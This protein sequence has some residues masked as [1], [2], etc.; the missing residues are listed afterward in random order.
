M[1]TRKRGRPRTDNRSK[2]FIQGSVP[3]AKGLIRLYLEYEKILNLGGTF[4][5]RHMILIKAS[6]QEIFDE[7][8]AVYREEPCMKY[9]FQGMWESEQIPQV[10]RGPK[11]KV[12]GW[13][14]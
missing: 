4:V 14:L 6:V 11:T 2:K 3:I 1:N 10:R 8:I 7:Y 5:I 12:L 13:T 9:Y